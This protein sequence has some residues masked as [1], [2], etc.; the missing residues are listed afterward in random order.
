MPHAALP[1][2]RRASGRHTPGALAAGALQRPTSGGHVHQHLQRTLR[3]PVVAVRPHVHV[4]PG[5][6]GRRVGVRRNIPGQLHV[7]P[8]R[9]N[10]K[11]DAG[12]CCGLVDVPRSD[13]LGG[14]ATSHDGEHHTETAG[15]RDEVPSVP[16]A[17]GLA[18]RDLTLNLLRGEGLADRAET[19]G[20]RDRGA[21]SIGAMAALGPRRAPRCRRRCSGRGPRRGAGHV[22]HLR[23]GVLG[24]EKRP[25]CRARRRRCRWPEATRRR[26]RVGPAQRGH[27]GV[28]R[29]SRNRQPVRLRGA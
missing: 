7:S 10:V 13:G 18:P 28:R 25:R 11:V 20:D 5:R 24:R 12:A 8:I 6:H 2:A 17:R 15:R 14:V 22:D 26:R 19:S 29:G 9:R 1:P 27:R 16:R 23:V 3:D 4:L 21:H